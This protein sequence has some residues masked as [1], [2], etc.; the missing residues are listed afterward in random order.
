MFDHIDPL[1]NAA[2]DVVRIVLDPPA[3]HPLLAGQLGQQGAIA[4]AKVEHP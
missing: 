3:M 4:A 2:A 1:G